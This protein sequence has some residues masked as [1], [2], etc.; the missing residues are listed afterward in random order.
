MTA[1]GSIEVGARS[2]HVSGAAPMAGGGT[3]QRKPGSCV[4]RVL[5]FPFAAIPENDRK[6]N[7]EED[8]KY[9]HPW[10]RPSDRGRLSV[11]G[12]HRPRS[13]V[14]RP[15][16][17]RKHTGDFTK[18]AFLHVAHVCA[19]CPTCRV[20]W[21]YGACCL[22]CCV[23]WLYRVWCFIW[24]CCACCFAY[25]CIVPCMLLAYIFTVSL[26]L[27]PIGLAQ[28]IRGERL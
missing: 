28:N 23:I 18:F 2:A 7:R 4:F 14:A 20:I 17:A 9:T 16:A 19:C 27:P 21:L 13:V 5:W 26:A 3:R 12:S 25:I 1:N 11:R 15:P 10:R 22:T 24:L 6:W 8:A